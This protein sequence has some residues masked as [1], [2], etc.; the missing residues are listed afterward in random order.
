MKLLIIILI[1]NCVH[2]FADIFGERVSKYQLRG[3]HKEELEKFIHNSIE[4]MVE[5]IY[6]KIVQSARKGKNDCQFI[7]MCKET[8]ITNCRI[9][10]DH[11][12]FSQNNQ[13][14]II[15]TTNAYI[16]F[17]QYTANVT[18]HLQQIF[19]DSNITK[20]YKNCCHYLTIKW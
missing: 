7:I 11:L 13:I 9:N 17:D 18:N 8:T 19:P 16:T 12:G 5:M 2:L 14:N 1:I 15:T 4:E 3:M 20:I 6:H 10:N